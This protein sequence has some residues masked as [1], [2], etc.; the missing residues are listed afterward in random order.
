M[1]PVSLENPAERRLKNLLLVDGTVEEVRRHHTGGRNQLS[2]ET[3][4][5][6]YERTSGPDGLRQGNLW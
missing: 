5:W 3:R 4:V 2:R 1:R 6:Q